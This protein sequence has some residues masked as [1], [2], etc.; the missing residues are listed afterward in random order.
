MIKRTFEDSADTSKQMRIPTEVIERF[1]SETRFLQFCGSALAISQVFDTYW[2]FAAERQAIFFRRLQNDTPVTTDPILTEFKFTNAYRA[3]DRVSQYLIKRVA[4]SGSQAPEEVFFRIIL[5]KLFNKIETWEMLRRE[6]GTVSYR[7]FCFDAYDRALTE[8]LSKKETIYSAAYI[9]PSGG[10]KGESRKHRSHLRLL[11]RMMCDKVPVQIANMRKMKDAFLLLRSYPMI[12][13]FLAFQFVT[14]LNYSTLTDF[15]EM[16]FVVA[17]PGALDGIRKCF[18]QADLKFAT[19]LIRFMTDIQ[20][21][22]FSRL[23]ISFQS[24]WGRP[25][26]LIDCQNLFC[27]VDKYS[28]RAHPEVVGVSGRTRIKQ[29]FRPHLDPLKLYYPPKWKINDRLP[30]QYRA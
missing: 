18:P 19:E 4:Y 14:D 21:Q 28:R 25:L 27:E 24:L 9:M 17:G 3:S 22:Q 6:V 2:R 12:G 29:Q 30:Q 7:E 15:D 8:A 26:Q 20:E 1:N 16:D 5:F 10:C 23:G 11:E 13:N